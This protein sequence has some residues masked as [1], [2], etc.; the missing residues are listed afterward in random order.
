MKTWIINFTCTPE[1]LFI[2]SP[3]STRRTIIGSKKQRLA[4][5]MSSKLVAWMGSNR[6]MWRTNSQMHSPIVI[7]SWSFAWIR[8]WRLFFGTVTFH[9]MVP[10]LM[11][12]PISRS[13]GLTG[14]WTRLYLNEHYG[15]LSHI[16][17][18]TVNVWTDNALFIIKIINTTSEF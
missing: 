11:K 8:G 18:G 2:P 12:T 6:V 7:T 14:F 15:L 16:M 3:R 1:E 13:A 17:I 4:L 9:M 10:N 5:R